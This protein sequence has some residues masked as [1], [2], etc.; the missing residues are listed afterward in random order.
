MRIMACYDDSDESREVL[1]EAIKHAKAFNAEVMLVISVTDNNKFF[2][3]MVE[4]FQQILNEGKAIFDENSII[5]K[6]YISYR[7]VEMSAGEDLVNFARKEQI[8]VILLGIKARS[9]IGKLLVESVAQYVI[10][11]AQCPVIGVKRKIV[12]SRDKG[13]FQEAVKI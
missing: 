2:S 8:D 11:N 10:L 3:K 9:R 5:C 4:F 1:R 13:T 7:G 12:A 6:T